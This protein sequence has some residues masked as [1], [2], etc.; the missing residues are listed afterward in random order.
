MIAGAIPLAEML[1]QRETESGGFDTPERRAALEGRLAAPRRD[2][3][4]PDG[5]QILSGR[6]GRPRS[7]TVR[8]RAGPRPGARAGGARARI[9]AQIIVR[10]QTGKFGGRGGGRGFAETPPAPV[11]PSAHLA[12][13]RGGA[14]ASEPRYRRAKP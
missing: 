9:G 3:S 12:A 11:A 5:A 14:R 6:L 4:R 2:D 7:R 8:H 1:W 13:Q 10:R